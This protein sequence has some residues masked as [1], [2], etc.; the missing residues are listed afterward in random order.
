M[1]LYI[2][3]T[4]KLDN[5]FLGFK[6]SKAIF[7]NLELKDEDEA[8]KMLN[9]ITDQIQ[10]ISNIDGYKNQSFIMK[11]TEFNDFNPST[12]I[13]DLNTELIHNIE[14][15]QKKYGFNLTN[16]TE[17]QQNFFEELRNKAHYSNM[18]YE[19]IKKEF[20]KENLW[21]DGGFQFLSENVL[22]P[23]PL[24]LYDMSHEINLMIKDF[25][26]TFQ[27][28][29][30]SISIKESDFY[31]RMINE[32]RIITNGNDIFTLNIEESTLL[33]SKMNSDF[34]KEDKEWIL[35]CIEKR[36]KLTKNIINQ[37]APEII[38]EHGLEKHKAGINTRLKL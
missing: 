7:M 33:K 13:K 19:D 11:I 10:E 12:V 36:D 17:K 8:K 25:N 18:Q 26:H 38:I 29:L 22:K 34:T 16:R 5:V 20:E 35:E 37:Y 14:L 2:D 3:K 27:R 4:V 31:D 21:I 6:N 1:S 9:P 23:I 28:Q 30:S 24:K 32:N 15:I